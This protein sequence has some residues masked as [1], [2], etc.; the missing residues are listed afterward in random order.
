MLVGMEIG[1]ILALFALVLAIWAVKVWFRDLRDLIAEARAERL[2]SKRW[3]K[4]AFALLLLELAAV[5]ALSP[6]GKR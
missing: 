1:T 6:W 2:G 5:V 4:V 3:H